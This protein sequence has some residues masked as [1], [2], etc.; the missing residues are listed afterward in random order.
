MPIALITGNQC[1]LAMTINLKHSNPRIAVLSIGDIPYVL[2]EPKN[3]CHPNLRRLFFLY[4]EGLRELHN[5]DLTDIEA[6]LFMPITM[7]AA[8][9]PE[10]EWISVSSTSPRR[11]SYTFNLIFL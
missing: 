9:V 6:P 2:N 1:I 7:S 3:F 11:E 8:S 4:L 10:R 5:W